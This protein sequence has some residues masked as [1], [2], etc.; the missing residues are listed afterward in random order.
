MLRRLIIWGVR[1]YIRGPGRSWIYT[2]LALGGL[3]LVRRLTGRR[4]VVETLEVSPGHPITIE[5]LEISHRRQIAD[6]RRDRKRRKRA[7]RQE[8]WRRRL[9]R[10]G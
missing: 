7:D 9:G 3:R 6:Q 4:P 2:T 1:A 5:Q 10:A 8:R